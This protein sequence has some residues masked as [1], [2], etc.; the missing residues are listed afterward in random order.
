MRLHSLQLYQFDTIGEN[1][2]A[3]ISSI[4]P[5]GINSSRLTSAVILSGV[6]MAGAN[7]GF[8]AE[9]NPIGNFTTK[10]LGL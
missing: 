4:V 6:R 5:S 1:V 9:S 7:L 2:N 8:N 3:S 10:W